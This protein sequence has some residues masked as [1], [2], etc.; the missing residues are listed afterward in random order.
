[1][2]EFS[3]SE[4]LGNDRSLGG[5][6]LAAADAELRSPPEKSHALNGGA[7]SFTW[8]PAA[9]QESQ[10]RSPNHAVAVEVRRAADTWAP[11]TKQ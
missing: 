11:T 1:M 3:Q 8:S 4:S 9:E 2:D 5:T 7:G 10:V 6:G